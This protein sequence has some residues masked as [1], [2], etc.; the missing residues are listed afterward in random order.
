[1]FLL[2]SLPSNTPSLTGG[3]L[4]EQLTGRVLPLCCLSHNK[5]VRAIFVIWLPTNSF[6]KVAAHLSHRP[7]A[8]LLSCLQSDVIHQSVFELIH[9]DDRALFRRQLHFSSCQHD[10][11]DD[12][13]SRL[14]LVVSQLSSS[15]VPPPPHYCGCLV[16]SQLN[17]F[18]VSYTCH[19]GAAETLLLPV[20][21]YSEGH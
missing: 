10:G 1:M 3:Q 16:T 21:V 12:S 9:T 7:V 11:A 20:R 5:Y 8:T 6:C 2:P 13:K 14:L 15:G 17:C 19:R 18:I 4:M